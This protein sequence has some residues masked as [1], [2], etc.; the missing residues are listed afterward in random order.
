VSEDDAHR[1]NNDNRLVGAFAVKPRAIS[2][3]LPL[4]QQFAT[5]C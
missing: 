3:A 2:L 4:Q 1:S 5:R